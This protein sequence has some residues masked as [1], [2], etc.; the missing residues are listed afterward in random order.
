MVII[1]SIYLK[2]HYETKL[3]HLICFPDAVAMTHVWL[4]STW[5][6]TSTTEELD[7]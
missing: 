4:L 5:K 1:C 6:V 2:G 3:D 7:F